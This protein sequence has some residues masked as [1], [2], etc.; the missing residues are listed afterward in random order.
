MAGAGS[1]LTTSR[2]DKSRSGDADTASAGQAA[3]KNRHTE[4]HINTDF[5]G[6]H[7][8]SGDSA[9]RASGSWSGWGLTSTACHLLATPKN[10][11]NSAR[12][13]LTTA[14]CEDDGKRKLWMRLELRLGLQTL[15]AGVG[16]GRL[17]W[18]IRALRRDVARTLD[19]EPALVDV[20]DVYEAKEGCLTVVTLIVS[21]P[22]SHDDDAFYLFLQ[23]QNL[24]T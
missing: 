18:L 15:V 6:S 22:A 9:H 2:V 12:R 16:N 13:V 7:A 17:G 1:A 11:I 19:L 23:K 20:R 24:S 10:C 4:M 5:D 21:V 14:P 3:R 8:D